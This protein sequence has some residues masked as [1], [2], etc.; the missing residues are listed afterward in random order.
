MLQLYQICSLRTPSSCLLY[1][2]ICPH[3]FWR[4]LLFYGTRFSGSNS[5]LLGSKTVIF[6]FTRLLVE[7]L[8]NNELYRHFEL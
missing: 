5:F 7:L 6:I 8:V 3:D 2:L 4:A 1:P